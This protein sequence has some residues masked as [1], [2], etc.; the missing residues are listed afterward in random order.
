M[1]HWIESLCLYREGYERKHFELDGQD[2]TRTR[3]VN[4]ITE[5][6][7]PAKFMYG[8]ELFVTGAKV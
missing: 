2:L 6:Y 3:D 1:R 8:L 4:W 5:A 7:P